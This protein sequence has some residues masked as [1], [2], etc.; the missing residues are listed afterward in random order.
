MIQAGLELLDA[1]EG[2]VQ[3]V[4]VHEPHPVWETV[5]HLGQEVSSEE[6]A[7]IP[8]D[9]ARN[10]DRHLYGISATSE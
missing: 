8:S 3:E 6:W 5:V 10:L 2:S 4:P 9:L 1:K 7:Q